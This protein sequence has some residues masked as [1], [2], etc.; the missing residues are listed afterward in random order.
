MRNVLVGILT[1]VVSLWLLPDAID[2]SERGPD[3]ISLTEA[4]PLSLRYKVGE[5]L[6]YRLS[7][8]STFF[9]MDGSKFGEHKALAYFIRTR[10]DDD[11]QGRVLERFTW[12]RFG[13]GESF[14]PGLSAELSYLEEAEGFSLILSVEDEDAISKF[15]FAGLPRSMV[16][17]WFMIMSWD[18]VTFDGPVRT[19]ERYDFP[20]EALIGAEIMG[21]RGP[22]DFHFQ[23]PPI[24]NDSRYSF[25]GKQVARVSGVSLVKDI[26]CAIIEFSY[27]ENTV[28]MNISSDPVGIKSRGFEHIWG[29]TYVSLQDGSIVK[30]ELVAPVANVQDMEIQGREEIQHSEYLLVQR[31]EMDLLSP[32][33]FES[34]LQKN[35]GTPY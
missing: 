6:H 21:T 11:S 1:V 9:A 29:R 18:A 31:L 30:G 28:H 23:Y 20:E 12:K 13:F 3:A 7:R 14:D 4:L 34:S 33:E 17:M 15:D 35:S 25:S 10:L 2:A 24:V 22:Y 8:R 19:Q 16:G 32:E 26:P 27:S 5:T